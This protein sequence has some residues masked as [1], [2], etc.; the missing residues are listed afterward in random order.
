MNDL[1][2]V[3]DDA[4]R[5]L[6]ERD[7]RGGAEVVKGGVRREKKGVTRRTREEER[8]RERVEAS[9]DPGG[10]RFDDAMN[11]PVVRHGGMEPERRDRVKDVPRRGVMALDQRER[12]RAWSHESGR[13]A[14]EVGT[15]S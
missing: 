5:G 9:G 7:H 1:S 11:G 12:K 15:T 10:G 2:E 13:G 4:T 14:R 3:L 6:L 8:R